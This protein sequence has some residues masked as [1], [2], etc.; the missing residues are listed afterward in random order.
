MET[1]LYT[2]YWWVIFLL[3][4]LAFYPLS[5]VFFKNLVDQGWLAGKV[6]GLLIIAFSVYLL[7]IFHLVKF[8]QLEIWLVVLFW[9][10]INYG[11]HYWLKT[12]Y[13][14][15]F[16][17]FKKTLLLETFFFGL[18]LLLAYVRGYQPQINGL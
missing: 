8:N 3:F 7:G 14:F 1:L 17:W 4:S 10:V 9:L 16:P 12:N 18:F 2:L 6:I 13:H 5:K 15:S 11:A